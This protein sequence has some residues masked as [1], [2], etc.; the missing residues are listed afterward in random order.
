MLAN[1]G[2]KCRGAGTQ[3]FGTG[4]LSRGAQSEEKFG[5]RCVLTRA[6]RYIV[7][8]PSI[9]KYELVLVQLY[10]TRTSGPEVGT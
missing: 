4:H 3:A 8:G 5:M 2:N 7:E 10:E 9:V 1:I 6:K